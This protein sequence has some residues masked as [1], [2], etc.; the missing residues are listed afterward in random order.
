MVFWDRPIPNKEVRTMN[1]VRRMDG[2]APRFLVWRFH[3]YD[4][5]TYWRTYDRATQTGWD[6]NKSRFAAIAWCAKRVE[7]A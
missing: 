2:S 5:G 3:A 6:F 7:P 4:N 1:S